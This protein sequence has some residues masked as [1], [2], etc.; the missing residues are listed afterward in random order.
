MKYCFD[1][2]NTICATPVVN[3]HSDYEKAVPYLPVIEF[4]NKK[5]AAGDKI[6]IFTARGSS[7]GI[8]WMDLTINQLA[9]WGVKY[10]KVLLGKPS[11]DLMVDDRAVNSITWRSQNNIVI[12]GFVASAFDLLHAGHVL[13]LKEAREHC[14]HL[15]VGLHIDPSIE[16]REK[17]KPV[18]SLSER[19]LMLEGS[20]YVDSIIIY[21]NE[22]DLDSILSYRKFDIRFLG[23]DAVGKPITGLEHCK[24]IYYI[25]RSHGY[26]SSELRHRIFCEETRI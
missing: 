17:N 13:M 19:K 18:Q 3:G 7:S 22:I 21:E 26:S 4:I 5:Y 10:H 16:R 6:T 9:D 24:N 14:D 8:D 20:R 25:D 23:D 1:L 15:T 2:D 12:R 11:Y